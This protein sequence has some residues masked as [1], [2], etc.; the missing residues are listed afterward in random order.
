MEISAGLELDEKVTVTLVPDLPNY[1]YHY[2]IAAVS[3]YWLIAPAMLARAGG[4]LGTFLVPSAPAP[5][6]WLVLGFAP[7]AD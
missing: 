5:L 7:L 2:L 1:A 6:T 3:L 4:H